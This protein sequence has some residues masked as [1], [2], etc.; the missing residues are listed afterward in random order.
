MRHHLYILFFLLFLAVAGCQPRVEVADTSDDSAV[1]PTDVTE[2][3]VHTPD[4]QRFA[5]ETEPVDW[6]RLELE[7]DPLWQSDLVHI[8]VLPP[9][10]VETG[11][12]T[13]VV[14]QVMDGAA[15]LDAASGELLWELD[16]PLLQLMLDEEFR[17]RAVNTSGYELLV[18]PFAGTVEQ[19]VFTGWDT[20]VAPESWVDPPIVQARFQQL[21][22]RYDTAGTSAWRAAPR[23][24]P[25]ADQTASDLDQED[26]S[27]SAGVLLG[28][29]PLLLRPRGEPV[30]FVFHVA[31]DGS[32]EF[33]TSGFAEQP[34]L[35]SVQDRDGHV[36]GENQDYGGLSDGF[37][38]RLEQ[39]RVYRAILQ[40]LPETPVDAEITLHTALLRDEG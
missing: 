30:E 31:A 24:E 10:L 2:P 27:G 34:V 38:V 11:E 20:M 8:G 12:L 1:E 28:Q 7:S 25:A 4:P 19:E 39:G 29:R 23:P 37:A 32:Y 9:V 35:L 36:L 16:V 15:A 5:A 21:G 6:G 3:G 22:I 40:P 33:Y 14:L 18:A 17:L 13:V 26:A